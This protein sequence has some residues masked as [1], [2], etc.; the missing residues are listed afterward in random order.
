[1]FFLVVWMIKNFRAAP[2]D[3]QEP[4]ASEEEEV[5]AVVMLRDKPPTYDEALGHPKTEVEPPKY[6]DIGDLV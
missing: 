2:A 3:G 6:E 5:K 1:M 4:T